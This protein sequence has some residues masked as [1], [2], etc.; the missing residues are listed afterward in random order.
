VYFGRSRAT[1]MS[2][3]LLSAV[4]LVQAASI[5]S[6]AQSFLTTVTVGD[7][8]VAI[9]VN[10]ATNKIYT[11][12]QAANSVTVIDGVTYNTL[13]VPTGTGPDGIA[14]NPLTNKIYVANCNSGSVTI[15]NGQTNTTSTVA[16]GTCP[17]AVAVN[18]TTNKIYVVNFDSNK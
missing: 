10:T 6:A 15:I 18:A 13:T 12:N 14:I 11:A 16:A 8:P 4:L 5:S 1:R 7:H 2:R 3:L 17:Y 9:A